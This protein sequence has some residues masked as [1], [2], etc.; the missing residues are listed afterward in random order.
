MTENQLKKS[1][2][3]TL[4]TTGAM[5]VVFGIFL[6]TGNALAHPGGLDGSGCHTC[7]TNCTEK[8][9]IPYDLYHCHSGDD[10]ETYTVPEDDTIDPAPPPTETTNTNTEETTPSPEIDDPADTIENVNTTVNEPAPELEVTNESIT[11]DEPVD[12]P[13]TNEDTNANT[14]ET[15]IIEEI[16]VNTVSNTNT[17]TTTPKTVTSTDSEEEDG[18]GGGALGVL[19]VVVVGGGGY[20][21]YKKM[22]KK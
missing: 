11:V 5:I 4:A 22:K 3:W 13:S 14:E 6:F 19:A 16:N 20:Y 21:A 15:T 18:G 12:L 10:R 7:R 17:T 1:T 9:N 8:Y 2:K